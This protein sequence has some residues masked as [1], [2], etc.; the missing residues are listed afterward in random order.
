MQRD[1]IH[2]FF[3]VS[4]CAILLNGSLLPLYQWKNDNKHL[5]A[6]L[7]RLGQSVCTTKPKYFYHPNQIS[8][9]FIFNSFNS[10]LAVPLGVIV[11]TLNPRT[12]LLLYFNTGEVF[13]LCFWSFVTLLCSS[14]AAAGKKWTFSKLPGF[15][16][17]H[18]ISPTF[19]QRFPDFSL[20]KF[21]KV[22]KCKRC[23]SLNPRLFMIVV[24]VL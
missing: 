8:T 23:G 9:R 10:W 1:L 11:H 3:R 2:K 17:I 14:G 12:S 6:I 22:R 5:T 7:S 21:F 4:H 18:N 24:D 19:S 13:F 20:T 15:P 16:I